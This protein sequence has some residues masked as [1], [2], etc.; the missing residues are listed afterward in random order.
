MPVRRRPA[1]RL[2]ARM[3]VPHSEQRCSNPEV[4]SVLRS[5]VYERIQSVQFVQGSGP[6][7]PGDL[8]WPFWKALIEFLE[9]R[10]R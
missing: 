1:V 3:S 10:G 7:P 5:V 8:Q 6:T 4:S 2:P 9:G